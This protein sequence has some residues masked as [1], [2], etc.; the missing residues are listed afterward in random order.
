MVTVVD[1]IRFLDD[2]A[3]AQDLADRDMALGDE[4]ER[5]IAHLLTDQV[6]FCDILL[7]NKRDDIDKDHQNKL[8]ATLKSLQPTARI[9]TTSHGQVDIGDIVNT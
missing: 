2:F 6:E 5:T 9:I 4:D 1:A 3:S 8:I 7:V